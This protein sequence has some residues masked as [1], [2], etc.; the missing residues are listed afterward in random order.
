MKWLALVLLLSSVAYAANSS[1]SSDSPTT[2]INVDFGP[3]IASITNLPGQIVS[4]FFTYLNNGL[5][6]ATKTITDNAI[7][8][9][10]VSPNPSWFCAPYNAVMAIIEGTYALVLM[11]LSLYFILRSGDVEGRL[12]AK[13]WMENMLVMVIVLAFS[14]PLFGMLIDLNTYLSGS[15]ANQSLASLFGDSY[16]ND[17]SILSLVILL[18]GSY[19]GLITFLTLLL[20]YILLPFM[21]LLFPISI[22]LYFIPP[23]QKWGKTFLTV[24]LVFIFMTTA[25]ALVMMGL[26]A[27]FGSADPN[28]ADSF[29]RSIALLTAFASFGLVNIALL[30]LALLSIVTQSRAITGVAG[31]T[32]L[33]KV[34]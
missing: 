6:S 26:A 29:V 5:A 20:R 17:E 12:T 25:D 2:I 33:A 9:M 1:S 10:F 13:K 14:F 28:L 19:F 22:F 21:L 4:S 34:L 15:L 23:M 24:I 27:M 7:K 32:L 31:L 16:A 3:V 30:L 8:F 11:G 18:S